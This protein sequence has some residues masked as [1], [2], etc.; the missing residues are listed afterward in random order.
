MATEQAR[1]STADRPWSLPHLPVPM[2]TGS[3][4]ASSLSM[5][6][7][8]ALLPTLAAPTT[9]TSRDLRSRQMRATAADMPA[10]G[11]GNGMGGGEGAG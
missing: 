2:A 6:R 9:N 1:P 4:R 8:K 10:G 11:A 5:A 7:T 3:V